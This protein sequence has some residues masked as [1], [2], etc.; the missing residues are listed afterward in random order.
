MQGLSQKPIVMV[1]ESAKMPLRV[2]VPRFFGLSHFGG[3][4]DH[5]PSGFPNTESFV[6][7][8]NDGHPP[9][10]CHFT[11]SL[12][13]LQTQCVTQALD[14]LSKW[15]GTTLIADCGF[16][17]TATSIAIACALGKRCMILC[18]REI[19]MRQWIDAIRQFSDALAIGWIQGSAFDKGPEG[20]VRPR[21]TAFETCFFSVASIESIAECNYDKAFLASFGTIVVDEMHHIAAQSL[22]HVL[23]MFPARNIV[24]LTATPNRADGLEHIL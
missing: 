4:V 7:R 24:G 23:P 13:P 22:V 3:F 2:G 18:N 1:Y 8:R 20:T 14:S 9:Q 19:L 15:G 11:K 21:D 17:K 10:A 6:D 12:R 5:G 16:G